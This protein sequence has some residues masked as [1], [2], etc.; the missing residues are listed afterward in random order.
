[1]QNSKSSKQKKTQ[2]SIANLFARASSTAPV[3][4]ASV[5]RS[6]PVE[7]EPPIPQ[8]LQPLPA[9]VRAAGGGS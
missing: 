3:D 7:L 6:D 8:N 9:V 5:Q 2:P 4:E 1:M